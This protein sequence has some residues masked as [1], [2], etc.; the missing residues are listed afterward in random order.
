MNLLETYIGNLHDIRSSGAAVKE[1][2][3]YGA[4]ESLLNEIG[5]T[6]KL[7]VRCIINLKNQGV[8]AELI[9]LARNKLKY[10]QKG[11][12]AVELILSALQPPC[13]PSSYRSE[14]IY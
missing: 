4:V 5:K 9:R 2:S 10:Y 11:L 13:R 7:R 1:T 8:V 12:R 6:L 14:K 3:Y